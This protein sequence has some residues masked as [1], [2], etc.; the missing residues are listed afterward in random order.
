M[1]MVLLL[2]LLGVGAVGAFG[3]GGSSDDASPDGNGGG[4][5]DGTDGTPREGVLGTMDSDVMNAGLDQTLRG[6]AGND[7]LEGDNNAII[8]GDTGA[9][10]IDVFDRATGYGG[11]GDD[12][13]WAL[14]NST[15]YG[16]E[17]ND[18]LG[19][20]DSS[21]ADGGAGDD[22]VQWYA[23]AEQP[24][25]HSVLIRGGEGNDTIFGASQDDG[26][27]TL[28]GGTGDDEIHAGDGNLA[29]GSFGADT[30]RGGRGSLL[31]GGEGADAFIVTYPAGAGTSVPDEAVTI[32][33]FVRGADTISV[34]LIGTP[35]Q[36]ALEEVDG[37]TRL[38]IDWEED[39]TQTS[40]PTTVVV[41]G[42]TG[43]TLEDFDFV[44][45]VGYVFTPEGTYE[46]ELSEPLDGPV[47]GTD[48]ADR[49]AAAAGNPLLLAGAGSDTVTA[50][51][52]TTD[53]LISMGDGDDSYTATGA[54]AD[55]WTG[56]G[57]DSID[58][59]TGPDT[60]PQIFNR[61]TFDTGAGDDQVIIRA[62]GSAPIPGSLPVAGLDIDLGAGN[63][64]AVIEKDVVRPVTVFDGVG[65]DDVTIWLGHTAFSDAGA[66]SLTVNVDA[67]HLTTR[68]PAEVVLDGADDLL[69]R[70]ESGISGTVTF[71]REESDISEPFLA[72]KLDGKTIVRVFG[73]DGP[74]DPR[75]SITRDAVFA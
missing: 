55:V 52:G 59:T 70:L 11:F 63:D 32:N 15:I 71:A 60:A 22:K 21:S 3:G 46:F 10:R 34:H 48:G 25:G 24:T 38:T 64:V 16:G 30:L 31:T 53:G 74:D 37:D 40:V 72:I 13:L 67:D 44:D 56:A 6:F 29:I 61:F 9:D 42:V 73:S 39:G 33:D 66:D 4:A 35:T 41:K 1:E 49:I 51:A 23:S 20:I 69:I 45:D 27:V 62:P 50:G 7:T 75:I 58:Y 65:D 17:G 18:F 68:A 19:A 43:M 26:L 5:D 54:M 28:A 36:V 8:H 14:G 2:A 57:N 47:F 12:E